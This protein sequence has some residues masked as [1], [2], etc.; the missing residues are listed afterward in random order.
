MGSNFTDYIVEAHRCLKLDGHLHIAE[1]TSRFLDI[2]SFTADLTRLGFDV[3]KVEARS[4]FTFIHAIKNE[5][6]PQLLK[7]SF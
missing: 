3:V 1:A 7:L 2:T 4:K 5:A 6:E